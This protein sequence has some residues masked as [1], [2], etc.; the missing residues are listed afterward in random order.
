M[1]ME[2]VRDY[3][4]ALKNVTED[5]PFDDV[6]LVFK[7][8]NRMFLLLS[9]DADEPKISLKCDAELAEELRERYHAVEP[10]YHFNKK[11]W[12]SIFLNRDMPDG[13]IKKW[14]NHSFQEVVAKL[15]KKSRERYAE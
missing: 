13:E 2:E 6:S 5:F 4:L 14:I 15:P 8:E 10:A 12:N 3:C 1:N 9:L 11:Y 7:V